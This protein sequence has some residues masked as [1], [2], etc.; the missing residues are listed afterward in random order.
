MLHEIT[1]NYEISSFSDKN[2]TTQYEY[3]EAR[4]NT[5][6]RLFISAF[7]LF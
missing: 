5:E 2:N 4:S 3:I 1:T 7:V 6:I